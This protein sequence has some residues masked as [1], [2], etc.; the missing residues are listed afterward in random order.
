[1]LTPWSIA[2]G[3]QIIGT[4]I[5]G[6]PVPKGRPRFN[7]KTG[8]V[9]TPT[10]TRKA[11]AAVRERLERVRPV[12]PVPFDVVLWLTF[13]CSSS[14]PSDADNLAKLVQDA[15][16]GVIWADDDQIVELHVR[17]FR[18][19]VKPRSEVVATCLPAL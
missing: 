2:L 7:H 3:E 19:A 17:R 6:E 12:R 10:I 5:V 11:E 8:N 4:V 15:G 13:H 1:M 9:Y 18:K 16:I 14:R